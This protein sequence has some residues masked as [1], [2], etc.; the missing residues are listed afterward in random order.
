[1]IVRLST[2][3]RQDL[4]NARE[5]IARDNPERA[6][7]YVD[8]LIAACASLAEFPLRFPLARFRT[9]RPVRQRPYGKYLILYEVSADH[10]EVV[11]VVHGARDLDTLFG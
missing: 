11:A 1:M 4:E 3:A 7:S 8:E 2:L 9:R 5:W 10:V 6:D